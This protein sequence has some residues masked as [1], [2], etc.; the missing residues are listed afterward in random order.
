MGLTGAVNNRR[1]GRGLVKETQGAEATLNDALI[2]F[3]LPSET[4]S[5][6]A[7]RS[8]KQALP[9]C[10]KLLRVNPAVPEIPNKSIHDLMRE[11]TGTDISRC[12]CCKQGTM[13][14]VAKL[15]K[16]RPWDSS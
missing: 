3:P 5:Q 1:R 11:L 4:V 2:E 13:V 6:L 9:Q 14:M 15:P 8:K 12:P 10:R 16:L 7:N